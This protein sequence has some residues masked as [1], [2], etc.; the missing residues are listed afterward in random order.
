M[1]G[2]GL[3]LIVVRVD[4]RTQLD[5]FDFDDLLPLARLSLL[6]LLL[7]L[8]LAVIQDFADRWL[9]VWRHL[10]EV[11]TCFFRRFER[12]DSGHDPL[13]FAVLIDQ[14]DFGNSDLV[15]DTRAVFGRGRWHWA[16]NRRV[17]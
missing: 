6:L 14:Q 9:G 3:D 12:G 11:Q 8:V 2:A 17:S 10:N 5:F 1:H 4:V 16:A 15:I 7:E 13:F